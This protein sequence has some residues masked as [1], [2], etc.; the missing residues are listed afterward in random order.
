MGI[1][2]GLTPEI[3]AS[4][5][6]KLNNILADEFIL[7]TKTRRAHWNV[8]GPNFHSMHLFFESQYEQLDDIVDS[9]AER[10]RSIGHYAAATLKAFLDLTHLSEVTHKQNDGVGFIKELL[11]D[12]ESLIMK[13][14]ELINYFAE[15]LQDAGS[16]D[17]VTGLMEIHE[18]MAWMLRAHLK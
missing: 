14:R 11:S 12:H 8:E 16:S 1:T 2:I 3:L 7:Y 9:V 18:K 6:Q 17:Y 10:I 4:V 5:A 13:L 15:N